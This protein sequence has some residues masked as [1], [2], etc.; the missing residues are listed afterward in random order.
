[1]SQTDILDYIFDLEAG[2]KL[3]ERG[4]SQAETKKSDLVSIAKQI[5]VEIAQTRICK[6]CSIDD[7]NKEF[8]TRELPNLGQSAGAVFR[9]SHW[10]FTGNFKKTEKK[11]SHGRE[12]KIWRLSP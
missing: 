11:S 1:M 6:T 4:I 9:G 5:A 10:T 12:I 3:K 7:V 8:V 2:L